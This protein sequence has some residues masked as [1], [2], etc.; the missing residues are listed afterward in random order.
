MLSLVFAKYGTQLHWRI[1][2]FPTPSIS[3]G[4]GQQQQGQQQQPPPPDEEKQSAAEAQVAACQTY[5]G[6]SLQLVEQQLQ[7]GMGCSSYYYYY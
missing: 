5:L 7:V 2:L 4:A 1:N 6:S 3:V